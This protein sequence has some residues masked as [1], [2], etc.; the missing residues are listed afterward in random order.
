MDR[1]LSD[2][3][4]VTIGHFEKAMI[5][6]FIH[7]LSPSATLVLLCIKPTLFMKHMMLWKYNQNDFEK[8]D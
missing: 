4:K 8:N 1:R 3:M 2:C 6:H 7:M 5:I